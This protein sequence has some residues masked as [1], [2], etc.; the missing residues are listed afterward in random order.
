VRTLDH[1]NRGD[2]RAL[3]RWVE[4]H[5]ADLEFADLMD[6]I[7]ESSRKSLKLK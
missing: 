1:V 7:R 2:A 6:E 5:E 4:E 3:M